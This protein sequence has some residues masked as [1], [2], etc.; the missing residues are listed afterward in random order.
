MTKNAFS[1]V[2]RI[3]FMKKNIAFLL[4]ILMS[5]IFAPNLWA[6]IE[7]VKYERGF[8]LND[9]VYLSVDQLRNNQ[10]VSIDKIRSQFSP[11]DPDYIKKLVQTPAFKI[12]TAGGSE[13][14]VRTNTLFGYCSNGV[15]FV[16]HEH[17][18]HRM[19]IVGQICYFVMPIE[20]S[21]SGFT[22]RVGVGFGTFGGGVGVSV[23]IGNSQPASKEMVLDLSSGELME[24]TVMALR[25]FMKDDPAISQRYESLSRRKRKKLKHEYIRFYNDANPLYFPEE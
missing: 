3:G 13:M 1:E 19:V 14:I 20:S 10:P 6:Q 25:E 9:G 2:R 22:P 17:K 7:G 21:G 8:K 5:F 23:P 18:F 15:P 16:K 11:E 4:L 24:L 12:I